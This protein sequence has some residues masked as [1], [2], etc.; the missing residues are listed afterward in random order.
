MTAE[1]NKT[2]Y[3]CDFC[4]RKFLREST[5]ASHICEYKHRWQEKDK[6]GNQI[7]FQAWVQF[8]KSHTAS[9]KNKT[10]LEYIK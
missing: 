4:N 3:S 9:N 6:R 10:Y 5:I 2:N 1:T 7:G 8:Y